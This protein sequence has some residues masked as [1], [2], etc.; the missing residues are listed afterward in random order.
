M[1]QILLFIPILTQLWYHLGFVHVNR[2]PRISI[3]NI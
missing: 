2:L 1:L 3:I